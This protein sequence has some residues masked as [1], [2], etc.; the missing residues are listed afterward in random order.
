MQAILYGRWST[1]EQSDGSTLNRQICNCTTF[2]EQ[3]GWTITT[4]VVDEGRSAYTG[5]NIIT[6]NL[7]KL[8]RQ[9]L[10]GEID[11][12]ETVL[13]VEELDRLSRQDPV[14]MLG[15]L[16]PLLG[17]GLS[18]AVTQSGQ[19]VNK[20]MMAGDVGGL[21]M[22]M[23]TAF[24]SHHESKKKAERVAAAWKGK[25][26]ALRAGQNVVVNHRHPLWV[27]VK[28]GEYRLDHLRARLVREIFALHLQGYGKG[29]IAKLFNQRRLT[30][31]DYDTWA[32]AKTKAKQWEPTYIGRILHNRTVIGLWE[33]HHHPRGGKRSSAGQPIKLYPAVVDEDTFNRANDNRQ[34]EQMRFQGKTRNVSNLFGRKARCVECG[35]QMTPL[36]SARIR[37]NP[38]GSTAQHYFLYCKNAKITKTCNHQR[39]WTYSRIEKPLLDHLLTK[40]MDDQHFSTKDSQVHIFE[41]EVFR[42]RRQVEDHTK[43]AQGLAKLLRTR[44]DDDLLVAE[45]EAASDDLKASK[46]GLTKA[47]EALA[48]ARGA[49][50]PSEHIKRVNEVRAMMDSDNF[51][52][53]YEARFR[54]KAALH[55]VLENIWFYPDKGFARVDIVGGIAVFFIGHDGSVSHF[56][57]HKPGRDYGQSA[58]APAIAGYLRRSGVQERP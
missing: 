1:L 56:N 30:D 18:I 33:P 29:A 40:A 25:R 15:W 55:D 2:A 27:V 48:V 13:V 21:M 4:I 34:R 5:D 11:G 28:H 8:A 47:Q 26:D 16:T 46:E 36:G 53:R 45:Y 3:K 7:G 41:G 19:V 32:R 38:D 54:V 22:L 10:S 43:G 58:D 23:V 20:D 35:G 17:A 14:T 49:V 51:D 31:P 42:L 57:L 9:I 6:G 37:T 39:G 50:S 44:S 12:R 24:G 52:E